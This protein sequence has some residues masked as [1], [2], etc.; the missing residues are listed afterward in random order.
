M[1]VNAK[2]VETVYVESKL[3]PWGKKKN[4][5]SC[6]KK[7]VPRLLLLL[8]VRQPASGVSVLSSA[9]PAHPPRVTMQRQSGDYLQTEHG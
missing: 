1:W 8:L 9:G 2:R 3:Q 6:L 7:G 4:T 5:S